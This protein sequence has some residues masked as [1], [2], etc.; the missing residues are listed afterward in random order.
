MSNSSLDPPVSTL[1]LPPTRNFVWLEL[2]PSPSPPKRMASP[3]KSSSWAAA[4]TPSVAPP[5]PSSGV[6]SIFDQTTPLPTHLWLGSFLHQAPPRASRQQSSPTSFGR[7]CASLALASASPLTLTRFLP[8]PSEPVAPWPSWSPKSTQTSSGSSA[9]GAR[10]RCS[11]TF[12][13]QPNRSC[14]TSPSACSTPTTPWRP[15]NSCRCINAHPP[16]PFLFGQW[17]WGPIAGDR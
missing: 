16:V 8:A 15:T 3:T 4:G 9:D 11:A 5:S 13:L 17:Q 6:S 1:T 7:L 12:T 2:L 10:M 14:A